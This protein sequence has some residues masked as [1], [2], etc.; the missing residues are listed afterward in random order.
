M[1][2]NSKKGAISWRFYTFNEIVTDLITTRLTPAERKEIEQT[3]RIELWALYKNMDD[4]IL[5]TYR[6]GEEGNPIIKDGVKP[7]DLCYEIVKT[8]WCK[9]TGEPL[10][11]PS[12]AVQP[13]KQ[14]DDNK[15]DQDDAYGYPGWFRNEDMD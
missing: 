12:T 1:D 6:L 8:V 2:L 9:L 11:D 4:Y 14:E 10:F 3:K 13:T 7:H 15:Y 5:H